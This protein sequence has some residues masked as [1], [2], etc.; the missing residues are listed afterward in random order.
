M[1]KLH[2][3][4]GKVKGKCDDNRV[5]SGIDLILCLSSVKP[6]PVVLE[7]TRG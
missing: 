3:I 1:G 5:V 7:V 6:F 4:K 2:Q